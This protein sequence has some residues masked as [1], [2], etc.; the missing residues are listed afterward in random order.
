V[1]PLGFAWLGALAFAGSL[2]CFLFAYFVRFGR[3]AP[4][5][6][7]GLGAIAIDVALFSMFA[8]HHSLF[9]RT[10]LKMLVSRTISPSLERAFYSWVA[11]ALLV[12]V[13]LAWVPVAGVVYSVPPPWNWIGYVVQGAGVVVTFFGARSLDVLDLA[14]VRQ[15]LQS[16]RPHADGG[17]P[18]QTTGVY[19]VV[20]HPL[21]FGWA[22]LVF[23]APHMTATRLTFALVST[24]Y[25][26]IAIPFEERGLDETFGA[27]YGEYRKHVRWRML[28]GLY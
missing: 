20:R 1:L 16:Q 11:S 6:S 13:C 23:G 19:G 17:V 12:F 2:A 22:L 28:P 8:L 25:L 15:V 3:T 21:Y 7:G 5:D 10:P 14:G 27:E 4:L 9:A 18:L 26:A 24:A